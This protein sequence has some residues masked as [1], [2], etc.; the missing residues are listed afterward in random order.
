[1]NNEDVKKFIDFL[2]INRKEKNIRLFF[3]IETL[4]YN[5]EQGLKKPTDYKNVT[6][7]VAISWLENDTDVVNL[8]VFP[9]YKYF[10]DTVMRGFSNKK[11]EVYKKTPNI[12]MIA[13]NNNKYD[14]H[15]MLADLL[16]YYPD[17]KT[18][19]IY[20]KM[21]TDE[22]N[23]LAKKL[24]D[25]KVVDKQGL[26]LEKR[27]KSS[28]NLELVIFMKGIKF[29]TTDN[30]MKT[31]VKLETLG[32]KL[33]NKKLIKEDEL[34]TDFDYKL[35]DKDY[36]MTDVEAHEYALRCFGKL[37]KF[38][39][40]YIKNDVIILAKAVYYY[41][42][43]FDGFDYSKITFTSN[44]L[45]FYNDNDLTSFQLLNKIGQGKE[46]M[47]ADYTDYKFANENFYDYLKPFYRGGL[48]FYNQNY[49]GKTISEKCFSIDINSSY[50]FAMHHFKIPTFLKNFKSYDTDT[51]V[52]ITLNDNTYTLYRMRKEIFDR[53]ILNKI[54]SRIIKQMLVKYYGSH[55]F[56]NINSYTIRMIETITDLKI[57]T[58]SVL[59]YIV[60]DTEF[61]GSRE[62]IQEN[63]F[64][65]TQGKNKN[66]IIMKTPYNIEVTD[67]ANTETLFTQ[68]EIDNSKV[69]LNGLYGIPALRPY[70]NLFRRVGDELVNIP[71]G[72]HNNQRNIVFSIFVTSVALYNLLLPFKFLTPSEIDESFIYSD[73]D[74]LYLKS[75]IKDKIPTSFFDDMALGKWG[76]DEDNILNISV[77]NHK[78]YAYQS[79]KKGKKVITVKSGGIPTDSFDTSKPF[80]QFVKE[81][82]S[83][84]VE[85]KNLKGIYNKGKTISLYES[86]TKLDKGYFYK[87]RMYNPAFDNMKKSMFDEIRKQSNFDEDDVLYI[88]SSIGTFSL[89]ELYPVTHE[90]KNKRPLEFLK[91]FHDEI[92]EKIN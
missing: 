86:S 36:D 5:K 45:E 92:K 18:E 6:Y 47:K 41:S 28:I 35:F 15:F 55:D 30:Y 44:I 14:N 69:L 49:I 43:I 2:A 91:W 59:S 57:D 22:G 32:T 24:G 89:T 50:P 1:M 25:L 16:F 34:K 9:N 20:L 63:Y 13:H 42:I 65:K 33:F 12:E 90:L 3:D 71:N 31:N 38:Q 53:T 48:N 27:I 67:E 84:G 19:D 11:G 51:I 4:L 58:L 75:K 60:Y 26:I 40:I 62:K 85:V 78:K 56:V 46:T 79:I 88:E 77:L 8:V 10:F 17:M 70:F 82:F 7:S 64:I 29:F 39:M 83:E 68:A 80:N 73:T 81:E 74:S 23:I 87:N 37:N 54:E 21:A 72:Y 61:F 52:E 76:I 66:K